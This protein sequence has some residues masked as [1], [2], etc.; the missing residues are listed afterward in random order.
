[1]RAAAVQGGSR[2]GRV[3]VR[4]AAVPGDDAGGGAVADVEDLAEGAVEQRAAGGPVGEGE[5]R[6]GPGVERGLPSGVSRRG[7]TGCQSS[8]GERRVARRPS[9]SPGASAA[10]SG[11]GIVR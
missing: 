1:M 10:G 7:G 3:V 11:S 6:A 5:Q 2:G 9:S 8:S 4:L